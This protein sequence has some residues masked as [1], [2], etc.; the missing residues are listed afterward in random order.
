MAGL[1]FFQTVMGHRFYEAVMP[2]IATA[3]ERIATAL[4]KVTKGEEEEAIRCD[5]CREFFVR[6]RC[7]APLECDCPKCQG[8]CEC[9]AQ[10][11]GEEEERNADVRR[12][13]RRGAELV[14][15]FS[16]QIVP[17]V[18]RHQQKQVLDHVANVIQHHAEK[19][20]TR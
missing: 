6:F 20:G 13:L 14:R 17:G 16:D 7:N 4:E 15:A 10:N 12:G 5:P 8:L 19:Y 9:E 1:E 2:R 18:S 11:E 3:L